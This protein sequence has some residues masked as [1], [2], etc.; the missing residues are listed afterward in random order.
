[1]SLLEEEVLERVLL[2]LLPGLVE[3]VHVQLADERGV[4]IVAEIHRQDGFG[5][6]L[7][8]LDDESFPAASPGDDV[9]EL[10]ILQNLKSFQQERRD[11]VALVRFAK[12]HWVLGGLLV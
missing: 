8:F 2:V 1:M 4:V 5:E 9:L 12:G 6:L 7:D 3:V 10:G 11:V